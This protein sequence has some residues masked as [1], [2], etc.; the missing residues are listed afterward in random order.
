MRP[1]WATAHAAWFGEAL[2]TSAGF[3][4]AATARSTS[5]QEVMGED[6]LVSAMWAAAYVRGLQEGGDGADPRFLQVRS[7]A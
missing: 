3:H 1:R 7:R 6:P 5:A 4:P 2:V